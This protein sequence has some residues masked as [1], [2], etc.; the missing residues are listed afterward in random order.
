MPV[1]AV[2]FDLDDTLYSEKEY[3][4]SG[5]KE[6]SKLLPQ[7]PGVYEKLWTAFAQGRLA[8]DAVLL[9]AGIYS[10]ELKHI[11]LDAYQKHVP[12]IE[13]YKGMCDLIVWLKRNKIKLGII[14]DGRPD[15]QWKKIHALGLKDLV[16]EIIITDELGGENFRKPND[17]A[18]RVM[19]R[20][21]EVPFEQMIYVGDNP[22]KDFAAPAALRMQCLYFKNPDGLYSNVPRREE[23]IDRSLFGGTATCIDE[24]VHMIRQVSEGNSK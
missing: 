1:D 19:Q 22:R 20:R 18:F 24:L 23:H 11:C 4:K 16:D 13:L 15:G 12:T 9:G 6:A 21:I 8:F 10:N 5:Y 2:I 7:I 17:F 3:V 14:T